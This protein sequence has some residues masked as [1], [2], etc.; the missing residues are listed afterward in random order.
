[1]EATEANSGANEHEARVSKV[2]YRFAWFVEFCAVGTGLAITIMVAMTT[3]ESNSQFANAGSAAN[4]VNVVIAALPFFLASVIE[5]AK[6]PAAQAMYLTRNIKWKILFAITLLFLAVVTFETA[7]N[8]FE[9]NFTNISFQVTQLKDQREKVVGTRDELVRQIE[10]DSKIT[11]EEVLDENRQRKQALDAKRDA[12]IE[13]LKNKYARLDTR[14][15][16]IDDEIDRLRG[17]LTSLTDE[18]RQGV[19][20]QKD[21]Q[22]GNRLEANN[23]AQKKYEQLEDAVKIEE[24]KLLGIKET[25]DLRY[26]E[27]KG[28]WDKRKLK[29]DFDTDSKAQQLRVDE[30]RAQLNSFSLTETSQD[31]LGKFKDITSKLE[32]D[33]DEREL[34]LKTRINELVAQRD[35]TQDSEEALRREADREALEQRYREDS[36]RLQVDADKQVAEYQ[37]IDVRKS[38]NQ[39][40]LRDVEDELISLNGSINSAAK[41]NQVYRL[42]KLFSD[43]VTI[44]EVPEEKIN[45][46]A[47]IWFGSLASIIAFTGILL[48]LASEVVKR[49]VITPQREQSR[50]VAS[51]LA[52]LSLSI[53]R[54][55]RA[56]PR[57]EYRTEV[58]EVVKE[59]PVE[60]VVVQEVIKEVIKKEV[61]HVPVYTSNKEVLKR[62]DENDG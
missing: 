11:L 5:L 42:A 48:A 4:Y 22:E 53:N 45:L 31:S 2:L 61:V 24:A 12:D 62:Q 15:A 55:V 49:Q 13:S 3:F 52:S 36:D 6:I 56:R 18:R 33:F 9:R 25:F 20:S 44:A 21:V 54:F 35:Q 30:A 7:I 1:M 29:K 27:A 41:D 43:G 17:E 46:I 38:E 19:Q 28:Y 50:G 37:S 16:N 47:K 40:K 10:E 8:G 26:S 14:Q 32:R 51:A 57:V 39:V 60:K 59:I 23:E 58:K 34:E